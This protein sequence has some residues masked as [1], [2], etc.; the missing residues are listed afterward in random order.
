MAVASHQM[1]K[2]LKTKTETQ[3]FAEN[4]SLQEDE[5][6]GIF[7]DSSNDDSRWSTDGKT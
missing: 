7:L 1:K 5:T 2:K 6:N 3:I 4:K